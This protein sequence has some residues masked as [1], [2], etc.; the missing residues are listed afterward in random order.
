MDQPCLP[1]YPRFRSKRLLS[2]FLF[3]CCFTTIYAQVQQTWPIRIAAFDESI[4]FPSSDVSSYPFNPAFGIGTTYMLFAE[5]RAAKESPK[6]T[7]FL[8]GEVGGY[9]HQYVRSALQLNT[10]I[11]YRYQFN[12]FG[13]ALDFGPGYTH[14]FTPEKTYRY[15]EGAYKEVTDWGSPGI[16]LATSFSASWQ[17]KKEDRS[18]EVIL[19]LRQ[20]LEDP[21]RNIPFPHFY[22]G[23]GFTFYPFAQ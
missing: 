4:S 10:A 19:I 16:H 21:F 23:A 18:P 11:G 12:R 6:A 2:C 7:W 9:H 13:L 3:V 17:L 1:F 22:A 8:L 14:A 5:K 20:S 15:E